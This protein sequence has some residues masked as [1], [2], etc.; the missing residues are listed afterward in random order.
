M[1]FHIVRPTEL[2]TIVFYSRKNPDVNRIAMAF[3]FHRLVVLGRGVTDLNM[4]TINAQEALAEMR[5]RP[6]APEES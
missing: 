4:G 6:L 1:N 2:T 5:P 3:L